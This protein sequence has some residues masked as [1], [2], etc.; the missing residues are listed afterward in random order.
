[1]VK[2]CKYR[3]IVGVKKGEYCNKMIK[4][5]DAEYCHLHKGYGPSKMEK[6]KETF[7]VL[8]QRQNTGFIKKGKSQSKAIKSKVKVLDEIINDSLAGS[9]NPKSNFEDD[10]T[11]ET[12]QLTESMP[13]NQETKQIKPPTPQA[14]QKTKPV[15]AKPQPK[16]ESI[17]PV[18]EPVKE[19]V[20][21]RK[22]SKQVNLK[23]LRDSQLIDTM[24][25]MLQSGLSQ[26]RE[27]LEEARKR[28]IINSSQFNQLVQMYL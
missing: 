26:A 9:F 28:N 16:R 4:I 18:K 13:T 5:A 8:E 20:Y 10:S 3:F 15:K 23:Q 21:E 24:T 11:E 17:E 22:P 6:H 19:P 2:L 1:M 25:E 7:E 27:A 14:F 12:D